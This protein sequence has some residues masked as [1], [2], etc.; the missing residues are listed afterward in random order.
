MSF[1]TAR[2]A[3]EKAVFRPAL[4]SC[5][6]LPEFTGE[7]MT[8][9]KTYSELLRDPRWQKMRLKKLEDAGWACQRCMD[10]ENTLNVHHNRYIKGRLPWEYDEQE[11]TVLCESCHEAEHEDKDLRAA[12]MARL[13]ADGPVSLGDFFAYGAGAMSAYDWLLDQTATAILE[14]LRAS[15][16]SQF[17]AGRAGAAL[18]EIMLG[19]GFLEDGEAM[20]KLAAR[21]S[22]DLQ[23]ARALIDFLEGQ[24]F[25]R[26]KD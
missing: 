1:C 4:P 11:L 12:F 18:F 26:R 6:L 2:V 16:P 7:H 25:S 22:D 13:A 21:L 24:G 19:N 9:K 10:S 3:P 23:F 14:Q 17:A 8:A 20:S 15:T 5:S